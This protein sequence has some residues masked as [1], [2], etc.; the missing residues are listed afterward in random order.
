MLTAAL[1][2]SSG[3]GFA[4]ADDGRICVA[5]AQPLTGRDSDRELVPWIMQLLRTVRGD[6]GNIAR[7]TIGTGPGS[8]SGIRVGIALVKGICAR[9]SAELRGLPSSLA[10]A[11]AVR[12]H[13]PGNGSIGVLHDA[14][15]GQVIL[16]IYQ[17]NDDRLEII[18]P[19]VVTTPEA[20]SV[21]C[22]DCDVLVTPH[23]DRIR[24]L[25]STADGERLVA[26][27][28]LNASLLLNPPGWPWP[29]T[30]ADRQASVEPIYVRPAVFV[31]P[32]RK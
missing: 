7:W 6:L 10:L 5:D 13:A 14:R 12:Q 11:R 26:V 21:S 25:L 23:A 28:E 1:D 30:A 22:A 15:R 24:A 27:S 31:K 20:L 4:L 29:E 3:A 18:E 19:A 8:F 16:T 2:T 17:A 9:S 32:N